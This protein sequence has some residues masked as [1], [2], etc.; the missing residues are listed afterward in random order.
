[1]NH[2]ENFN[3]RNCKFDVADIECENFLIDKNISYIRY[4]S[5][6]KIKE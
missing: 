5:I 4:V 3:D 1:M 2:K 6:N